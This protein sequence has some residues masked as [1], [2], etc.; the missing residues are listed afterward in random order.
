MASGNLTL[1]NATVSG[2]EA[3]GGEGGKGGAGGSGFDG[4]AGIAGAG[5]LAGADGGPSAAGQPGSHGEDGV[6]GF[7]GLRGG[8]G[9]AGGEGGE[10]SGGGI[11]V[12]DGV[13]SI[14]ES[15]LTD[16][17]AHGGNGGEGGE[18]GEGGKG[19]A[20]G[21]AGH[22]GDGGNGGNGI[23]KGSFGGNGGPGA[24]GALGGEGGDGAEG[25][26]GGE[27]ASGGGG[28]A[29]RG[30]AVFIHAGTATVDTSTVS[31]DSALGGEGGTG[32]D[33]G[34]GGEGGAGGNGGGGGQGGNGGNGGNGSAQG[35]NG[36]LGGQN[37][38]GAA[39]ADGG[40][41]GGGADGGEG[42]EGGDAAGGGFYVAGGTLTLI[43][44][45]MDENLAQGGNGAAGGKGGEG[46]GKSENSQD[47][48]KGGDGGEGGG[49]TFDY[50]GPGTG[51]NGTGSNGV[52][53]NGL[54]GGNGLPGGNAGD[55]ADGGDGG[56]GGRGGGGGL[57]SGGS[58]YVNGGTLDLSGG[59]IKGQV[60]G[61]D[62]GAG[63]SGG[64]GGDGGDGGRGGAGGFAAWG[65]NAG[66]GPKKAGRGG[67]SGNG[68]RGGNGGDGGAGGRGGAGGAGG[69]G[70]LARG[71]AIF[72]EPGV[73][74]PL[75][76]QVATS[77]SG[78]ATGG[79]PGPGGPGAVGGDGG[80]KGERGEKGETT[81]PGGGD[82]SGQFGHDGTPGAEGEKGSH[83][84]SG[85]SGARGL[86]GGHQGDSSFAVVAG[87]KIELTTSPP[88]SV[89][90]SSSFE[91]VAHIVSPSGELDKAFNG[92]V[93]VR[94]LNNPTG[95]TLGGELTVRAVKGVATFPA[96]TIDKIGTGYTV[97][98]THSG[99][100]PAIAGPI[101]VTASQLVVTAQPP[102]P[103]TAGNPFAV[104]VAAEDLNGNIDTTFTGNVTLS[105][106]NGPDGASLGGTVQVAAVNGIAHFSN[107]TLDRAGDGYRLDA[108]ADGLDDAST[109]SFAVQAGIPARLE[110]TTVPLDNLIASA[111]FGLFVEAVDSDGNI[112]PSFTGLVTLSLSA[113]PSGATFGGA[114]SVNAVGGVATFTGLTLDRIGVGYV[115]QASA[116]G[117]PVQDT[118]AFN[119]GGDRLV[120]TA[121]PPIM[122][123]VRQKF[124]M[125]VSVEDSFGT[126]DPNFTGSIILGLASGPAG[127]K[128]IGPANATAVAGVATFS[129][130]ALT[131][132]GNGYELFAA[133]SGDLQSTLAGPINV[134]APSHASG[135]SSADDSKDGSQNNPDVAFDARF[136]SQRLDAVGNRRRRGASD[137]ERS[138]LKSPAGR[139]VHGHRPSFKHR[140]AGR[141]A[142]RLSIHRGRRRRQAIRHSVEDRRPAENHYQRSSRRQQGRD[143][144]A[145]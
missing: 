83:G 21:R 30:G 28:G 1:V 129:G 37:A 20:G 82:P 96:V 134:V 72:S 9:G 100:D 58:V 38:K 109:D 49:R 32:G 74:A 75:T 137:A 106:G 126:V 85:R 141:I 104:D 87:V 25:S 77:I 39:G 66:N 15:T 71:G 80:D 114:H 67:N 63:G 29:A 10:A 116:G 4:S 56:N 47:A 88:S 69:G 89:H 144:P 31:T 86:P 140:S 6:A 34:G 36:G 19:G 105:L 7:A 94:L 46:G 23:N 45:T 78:K 90:A 59:S 35:G 65:G 113:N 12:E 138:W 13:L 64:V 108:S 53:G 125:E 102:N 14:S 50:G 101:D 112:V 124:G 27:G 92:N 97:Q 62:G 79:K 55:G 11:Y 127:G 43:N 54:N 57:A 111:P 52:G 93:T 120:V 18:G 135:P 81:S 70:G 130:L 40:E 42:G 73:V 17:I 133:T 103:A 33:G 16:N 110:I 8:R 139:L 91:I 128:L 44:P 24:P 99:L 136:E 84:P 132:I 131:K 142:E 2:N 60:I 98:V 118:D 119:V 41:G 48:G 143:D 68:A 117:V 3:T 123:G 22:G 61:G 121:D 95:A 115:I 26:E 107:L 76:I 5:G 122:I 145:G 51:G